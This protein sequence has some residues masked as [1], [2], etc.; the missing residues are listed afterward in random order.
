V[1]E[2]LDGHTH[3]S[4]PNGSQEQYT[5]I[6]HARAKRAPTAVSNVVKTCHNDESHCDLKS[7]D[8]SMHQS[9]WCMHAPKIGLAVR[10]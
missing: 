7:S 3:P 8:A 10:A 9:C 2:L 1:E 4:K 5:A 6:E